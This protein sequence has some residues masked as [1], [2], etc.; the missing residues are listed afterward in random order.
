MR[1]DSTFKGAIAYINTLYKLLYIG[2]IK[3]RVITNNGIN[4]FELGLILKGLKI[5]N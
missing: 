2:D 3:F 1:R 5:N 4:Y